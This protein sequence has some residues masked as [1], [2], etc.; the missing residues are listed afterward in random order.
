MLINYEN[1]S[2]DIF[3][4]NKSRNSEVAFLSVFNKCVEFKRDKGEIIQG[5]DNSGRDYSGLNLRKG[6]K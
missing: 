5:G 4:W 1:K 6:E 3:S 2:A